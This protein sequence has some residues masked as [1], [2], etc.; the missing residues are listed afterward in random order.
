MAT[1]GFVVIFD[2]EEELHGFLVAVSEGEGTEDCVLRWSCI[3]VVVWSPWLISIE[4]WISG[5]LNVSCVQVVE[6]FIHTCCG[7]ITVLGVVHVELQGVIQEAASFFI[8]ESSV[9]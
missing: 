3:A 4:V 7:T 2:L 1:V 6:A 9:S 5:I 8:A